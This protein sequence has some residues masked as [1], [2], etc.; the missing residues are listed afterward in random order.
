[1]VAT[2]KKELS[3]G[4]SYHCYFK[5]GSPDR[6]CW[7]GAAAGAAG[8]VGAGVVWLRPPPHWKFFLK[9]ILTF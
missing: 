7:P 6:R 2:F 3:I 4:L 8:G 1:M 5:V 9:Q